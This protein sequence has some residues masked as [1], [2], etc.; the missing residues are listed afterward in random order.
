MLKL[1]PRLAWQNLRKNYRVTVP[2]LLSGSGIIMMYYMICALTV[3]AENSEFYG[4]RTAASALGFGIIVIAIFGAIF[5]F[6]TNSFLMKRRKKELGLYNILGMEKRHIAGVILSET[7]M[8]ALTCIGLGVVLGVVFSKV[9]FLILEKLLGIAGVVPFVIPVSAIFQAVLLFGCIF[10]VTA[11]YNILQVRLSK[12]I[13]LLHGGEIGEKEPKAHW[14]LAILGLGLLGAGYYLSLSISNPLDALMM[15]FVAVVLVILGTY[16]LFIVGITALLKLLKK[17][18]RFYYKTQHFTTVSGMLYRMKQNA[19]GLASIC[20]LFT[21]LLV[22]VSTTFSLYTGVDDAVNKRC[23]QD[24]EMSFSGITEEELEVMFQEV[25]SIC[26]KNNVQMENVLNRRSWL[27]ACSRVDNTLYLNDGLLNSVYVSFDL[28]T[29]EDYN[30]Y[31]NDSRNLNADEVLL[32]DPEGTFPYDTMTV[33]DKTYQVT[34]IDMPGRDRDTSYMTGFESYALVLGDPALF[35]GDKLML[36]DNDREQGW[37]WAEHLYR[38]DIAGH[39]HEA[40]E[41]VASEIREWIDRESRNWNAFV[42]GE[43]FSMSFMSKPSVREDFASLYGGVFFLGLFMGAMFL[44]GT[45]LIMYYKQVSEGYEDAKRFDIM[46]KVGMSREE[47]KKSI[48]S[49]VLLVFF[50]PLATAVM[51]LCFAFPML[52]KIL[53]LMNAV[54]LQ[55]ILTSMAGCVGVF[56][57]MYL[58][59]YLLTARTY[60]RIVESAA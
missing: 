44:M 5:L 6:Y 41:T 37:Y 24:I 10:L 9:F 57:A 59:I 7:L 11:L 58:V 45:V 18:R 60:Y 54:N 27:L 3:G 22:T 34:K 28:Y 12:P 32:Y 31:F 52:Q 56:G 14:L 46:Q 42:N 30:R 48:H 38:L 40:I 55:L 33:F 51:H 15:F 29:L 36:A 25:A 21:C 20:I 19:A 35:D 50:L 16:L 26:A 13:E 1:Y 49:Q 53:G 43:G 8:T 23:P 17:N 39:D 47:V 2:Y 4:A